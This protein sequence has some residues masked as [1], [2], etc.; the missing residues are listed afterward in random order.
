MWTPGLAAILVTRFI[1]HQPLSVLNLKRLGEKH[2]YLWAWL[3]PI[4]FS[5]LTGM[6]TWAFGL[7]KLDLEFTL[8][9]QAMSQAPGGSAISPALVVVLQILIAM[10]IGPLFNTL[11]AL[12]EELGWRGYLFPRLLPLGQWRAIILTGV[13]WGIWHS[14]V[15]LQGQNYPGHP[16][17]GVFLMIGFCLLLGT[18]LSWLFLRTCNPWAPALAH[19]TVNAV[20][21]LPLMFM[22]GIDM[23]LGGTLTSLTGWIPM[24]LFVIW[25][26][27]S[28]R[29]PMVNDAV[30]YSPN[31]FKTS[32]VE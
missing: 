21:G 15:I 28:K 8:I 19:G 1:D 26:V 17:L 2:A 30:G 4:I 22:T 24:I 7:G 23:A 20:A 32:Q 18:I 16:V 27:W 11:F 25:L 12:G 6:L 3:L 10:T 13:I 9:K 14:P 29:L 5:I 31:S